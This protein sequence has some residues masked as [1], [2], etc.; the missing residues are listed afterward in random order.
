MIWK[1]LV[2]KVLIPA[3]VAAILA[4]VVGA[5]ATWLVYRITRDVPPKRSEGGFRRGQWGSAS[6]VSLA[7]GTGDAQKTMGIIFLALMSYG[8]PARRTPYR[9][10]GSS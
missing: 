7:H 4:I 6:L 3:V 1:G 8:A 2:S 5:I 10:C 9:R